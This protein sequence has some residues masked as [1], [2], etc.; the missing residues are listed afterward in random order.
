M[1][2]CLLRKIAATIFVINLYYDDM[3]RPWPLLYELL[4][5]YYILDTYVEYIDVEYIDVEFGIS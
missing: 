3:K 1:S 5:I 4:H 2:W